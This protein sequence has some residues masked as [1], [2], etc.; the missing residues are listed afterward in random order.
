[1][2]SPENAEV[3]EYIFGELASLGLDPQVQTATVVDEQHGSPYDA[4]TAYNVLARIEGTGAGEAEAV[5]LAAHYDSVPTGP[6][7]NDDGAGVAALLETARAL[8]AGP[9]PRNDVIFLFTDGEEP[10]F[11]GAEAFVKEHP[12]A[13]DISVVLNFEARG[14]SGPSMMFETSAE[15]GRL[16]EE[17]ARAAPRPVA[18]SATYEVYKRTPSG[19]DPI[20]FRKAE[21][22]FFR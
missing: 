9:R 19:D 13:D 4:A 2:G 14:N 20:E 11:L 16:V 12:W 18:S 7:A 21:N 1:M 22:G 5:M 6:G 3:R 8:S 17:F 10:G 15:N